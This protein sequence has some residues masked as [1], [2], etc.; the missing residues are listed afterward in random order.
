MFSVC[1]WPVQWFPLLPH[2]KKGVGLIPAWG[3]L[4]V[5]SVQR[6]DVRLMGNPKLPVGTSGCFCIRSA[7]DWG[8]AFGSWDGWNWISGRKQMS[9]KNH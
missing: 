5:L 6:H 7:T 4:Y 8:S 9:F 3:A 2:S 1:I